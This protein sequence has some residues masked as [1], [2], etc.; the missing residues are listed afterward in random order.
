MSGFSRRILTATGAILLLALSTTIP[1]PGQGAQ[2][3]KIT[4]LFNSP[5][6]TYLDLLWSGTG[7]PRGTQSMT[8][9]PSGS[10]F[11]WAGRRFVR[12]P[13]AAN[14]AYNGRSLQL[15]STVGVLQIKYGFPQGTYFYT[16]F[17]STPP[18][19]GAF[20]SDRYVDLSLMGA[21]IVVDF[22]SAIWDSASTPDSMVRH[23]IRVRDG[24]D[25]LWYVSEALDCAENADTF[26]LE[27][28][29]SSVDWFSV[30]E[31]LLLNNMI[32]NFNTPP[33][34]YSTVPPTE[35]TEINALSWG[36]TA[37]IPNFAQV[38]GG[39]VYVEAGHDGS[40]AGIPAGTPSSV[41]VTSIEWASNLQEIVFEPSLG[42]SLSGAQGFSAAPDIRTVT[43]RNIGGAA[44]NITG[45]QVIDENGVFSVNDPGPV[46]IPGGGSTAVDLTYNPAPGQDPPH[47]AFL[48]VT[49][50]TF[51]VVGTTSGL[52]LV[53]QP[54]RKVGRIE[55]WMP[56]TKDADICSASTEVPQPTIPWEMAPR[57]Y[58][59]R[60][61][62]FTWGGYNAG[63]AQ[64]MSLW[65]GPTV[66]RIIFFG[67]SGTGSSANVPGSYCYTIFDSFGGNTPTQYINLEKIRLHVDQTW[68]GQ[69]V[70][71]LVRDNT[72]SW[73]LSAGTT[74]VPTPDS[75]VTVDVDE[76]GGWLTV[77]AAASADMNQ[78]DADAKTPIVDPGAL[79][80]GYPDLGEITGGGVYVGVG[81]DLADPER[82]NFMPDI[83]TW[84]KRPDGNEAIEIEAV[85]VSSLNLAACANR[86]IAMFRLDP[87]FEPGE[88]EIALD[89]IGCILPGAGDAETEIREFLVYTDP[90]GDG[91]LG[92]G[93][94]IARGPVTDS[95]P[96]ALFD[97][98]YVIT[99]D[100]NTPLICALLFDDMAIGHTWQISIESAGFVLNATTGGLGDS[101]VLNPGMV[102]AQVTIGSISMP[103]TNPDYS[104]TIVSETWGNVNTA[105][106][107]GDD[108][109]S[110]GIPAY[111]YIPGADESW[112]HTASA[113]E[114][115]I[116][117]RVVNGSL[118]GGRETESYTEEPLFYRTTGLETVFSPPK[119]IGDDTVVRLEFQVSVTNTYA[120][121]DVP[122]LT[123]ASGLHTVAARSDFRV[124][125]MGE[126]G[127]VAG[128]D[129]A[130]NVN[131]Y[132]TTDNDRWA[133]D[134]EVDGRKQEEGN[135]N[136]WAGEE[137]LSGYGSTYGV[138]A[139]GV[140]LELAYYDSDHTITRIQFTDALSSQSETRTGL[141]DGRLASLDELCL[142]FGPFS[143]ALVDNI[144]LTI[145]EPPLTVTVDQA[146]DQ[147]DPTSQTAVF[148]VHFSRAAMGL[149]EG[150][151]DWID[152]TVYPADV[153]VTENG[154]S[155]ERDY[156]IHAS[157]TGLDDGILIPRL[158]SGAA[159]DYLGL[160]S[161][162]STSTDHSVT[163]DR[164]SPALVFSM[165]FPASL[166]YATS[167]TLV[168][169][170]LSFTEDVKNLIAGDLQASTGAV[171]GF[172]QT[173]P[174]EF[175]FDAN[176]SPTLGETTIALPL[177]ACR[178][179]AGNPSLPAEMRIVF[180]D[181]APG[182]PGTPTDE[183]E[184][185]YIAAVRFQ[186][187]P[188]V[189]PV[190]GIGGYECQVGAVPG[191]DDLFSGVIGNQT[192]WT[193]RGS[194][195][196]TLYCRVRARD[197]AGNVGPWSPSSDGILIVFNAPPDR[198]T[199]L[200]PVHGALAVLL[201]PELVA[202]EFIDPGQGH[203]AS[204]WQIRMAA[205]PAD[206]S[207][208]L[209]ETIT[210][211]GDLSRLTPPAEAFPGAY[212]YFWRVRYR[213]E[214]GKWS[215][216]S[217][218]TSLSAPGASGDAIRQVPR[219]EATF[220]GPDG[221]IDQG[222]VNGVPIPETPLVIS[223]GNGFKWGGYSAYVGSYD[224][225]RICV[226]NDS[227]RIIYHFTPS[228][229]A[230][231][232]FS[233]L[234]NNT[235][236]DCVNLGTATARIG[237]DFERH[238]SSPSSIRYMLL[239]REG[240]QLNWYV[241]DPVDLHDVPNG[242]ENIESS[243]AALDWYSVDPAAGLSL[244]LLMGGDE[245]PVS[246]SSFPSYPDLS[247]IE[248][249]G[250]YVE[251]GNP[252]FETNVSCQ[253]T[254]IFWLS[255]YAEIECDVTPEHPDHE[256]LLYLGPPDEYP[257]AQPLRGTVTV[258]N[259]GSRILN[260]A[261]AR[262]ADP[263]SYFSVL[264][265]PVALPFNLLPGD[266]FDIEVQYAPAQPGPHRNALIFTHNA[267]GLPDST[268][269]VEVLGRTMERAQI[270]QEPLMWRTE[271]G[272]P[273]L[274]A[275]IGQ[276][277]PRR[278]V[279]A[280]PADFWT[281]TGFTWGAHTVAE[282]SL[283]MFSRVNFYTSG[284]GG[285]IV[286][287]G[288]TDDDSV[289]AAN[290]H[291]SY[292]YTIFDSAGGI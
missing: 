176:L 54:L 269:R 287:Y 131:F 124:S 119:S 145:F 64:R 100:Q 43:V 2:D 52:V 117:F 168:P 217:S 154:G 46:T 80:V 89:S 153:V 261:D 290:H 55:D 196:Q 193:V 212:A 268:T 93:E 69:V 160:L 259:V 88:W 280:N 174:G 25:R 234:G 86:P 208:L 244:N 61:Y 276:E 73:F 113:S 146:A 195:G 149:Y 51:G 17:N 169:V 50:D 67:V 262:F 143:D 78:L 114:T 198:P 223:E 70:R 96:Q 24:A 184:V 238:Y 101:V 33:N 155:D 31:N 209:Y 98:P 137:R 72:G 107:P 87:V 210:T 85:D 7:T 83:F 79:S 136:L 254:R 206:Y 20:D 42:H 60:Y 82:R 229:Y 104:A 216:W 126:H 241:S 58:E 27:T 231:T 170:I 246:F 230:Y 144:V 215:L 164:T 13:E 36:A 199:N 228:T 75:E 74:S 8:S 219:I 140:V 221:Y 105:I 122:F 151:I 175:R 23:M 185:S 162:P 45:W 109:I 16:I 271:M 103:E 222:V 201:P 41:D 171:S 121:T 108:V 48:V 242:K 235:P 218:E 110:A 99:R 6:S 240:E 181:V 5:T 257:P 37:V 252:G 267:N 97:E 183:G 194:V 111:S 200:S 281:G 116:G 263:G 288:S 178:D 180:D 40:T 283:S 251:N 142:D 14:A 134:I 186:W 161:E 207:Q 15:Y 118:A 292:C 248:G 68:E 274:V 190:S 38:D 1:C 211:Q 167:T 115:G 237:M 159:Y 133:Y 53:G 12:M 158:Q 191:S 130:V 44:L 163:L 236:T 148:D 106:L 285:R 95:T 239:A 77:D 204:Q 49:S 172:S 62:G 57:G 152:G 84:I 260:L 135:L 245:V 19:S 9:P 179:L 120:S 59:S 225:R 188:A 214:H 91:R 141:I 47:R 76:L 18:A 35:G 156:Q 277:F 166:P 11:R 264:P 102:Q 272:N 138:S 189:D 192:V 128:T 182:A 187:P 22:S 129:G 4:E 273:A 224:T 177:D 289:Y 266:S 150:D 21:R 291:G 157:P 112:W 30:N 247:R 232:V 125:L 94:Q 227:L 243:V 255:G 90:N 173:G 205:T 66:G 56:V 63:M 132:P 279:P 278:T 233:A 26:L 123:G 275:D 39:G 81:D 282:Q 253:I 165:K 28:T 213:D 249:G 71:W 220:P 226:E 202:S 32:V 197:A 127:D 203:A 10:G 92:D 65:T 147:A 29:V 265:G 139:Y 284:R 258:R 286:F 250:F 34:N 270:L 3:A 256:N